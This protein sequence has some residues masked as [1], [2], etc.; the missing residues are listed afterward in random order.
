MKITKKILPFIITLFLFGV[1]SLTL[2]AQTKKDFTYVVSGTIKSSETK[3]PLSGIRIEYK[4]LASAM[5]KEEGNFSIKLPSG[6][7]NLLISGPGYTSKIV[8]VKGRNTINIELHPEGFKSVFEN[9]IVPQG[10]I[11]PLEITSTWSAINEKNILKTDITSDEILQGKV[12]GVNLI[13]RSGDLATG[14]NIY[15]RGLNTMNAGIQPLFVVDGIPYENSLYSTSLIGN[16]FSNPLASIDVKDIESIT[17]LKDGTSQYGVKGANGVVLIRT[18]KAKE[19]ETKINFHLHSGVSFEPIEIPVLNATNHK[20]LLSDILQSKGMSGSDIMSLPYMNDQKP[21]LQKWGYDGNV[22]Y[23]RYNNATNW[24]KEIYNLSKN[25]DY[26]MNVFGG[27][28]VAVYALSIGFL[29]Q[30]GILKNTNYQRFNTRFNSEVN[31]S[32][33]LTLN[34]NMSFLFSSRKLVDEGASPNRNPIFASLVK[35]P[36]MATN[37]YSEEG[38]MSPVIEDYD[39]FNYSNPYSL[40][41]KSDRSNSQFRFV[42]NLKTTYKFNNNFYMDAM[43]GVNF[44]KEREKLFFPYRGVYFDT[45]SVGVV[46]NISQHRV[47]RVF[48]LYSE[49][50]ANYTKTFNLYH[51][52]NVRLGTRYQSNSAEDDWGTIANTG[53]DNFR[54][55]NYGDPLY[56]VIGGQISNWN[57]L[58]IYGS[59]DYAYK[60]KYFLNYTTSADA[61]SRYGREA[62]KLILYPSVSGAWLVSGEEFLKDND[63][64]DLLKLRLGYGLS[65]NDDIGNYSGAQYYVPQNL[66]GNFGLVRGNLVDLNIKPEKSTKINAGFDAA[67]YNER[68]SLIVDIYSTTI[69]DMLVKMPAPRTSGFPFY[70]TNGGVMNNTGLDVAL[71]SRI[72]NG[73][74]KWDVGLNASVYHNIVTDLQDQEYTT[75]LLGADVLTKVGKSLGVFYGYK[76][77]GVYSTQSQ[78]NEDGLYIQKGS[79]KYYFGAG[80][81]R[82]V[83]Q[84]NDK[85]IDENDKVIIGNPN[86][87]LF[88][89]ITSNMSY[90]KLTLGL[91]FTYSLGNDV[92]N[93]TRSQ[94]ESMS[95]YYNQTQAVLNRW[96]AEGDVTSIPRAVYGDPMG[97]ARFSDRWIEDGSY[98][99]LKNVNLSYNLPIK[100]DI[101]R[102]ITVFASGENLFTLTKYKGLDPE[103]ALGQ[104]PLYN[105][106]DATFIPPA[107]TVSLGIKLEL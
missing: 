6:D 54:S 2:Q 51:K 57:W 32:K 88:G 96:K 92:Y 91:L 23:Y 44:N 18:L 28:E 107:R 74:F 68:L 94:L 11:S 26:Y 12:S 1:N 15:I 43:I 27:D 73:I 3:K 106:I 13:H 100:N 36:F 84:N 45:L 78:A 37:V 56:R 67:F 8:S 103:F 83:N 34:A 80:D 14:S 66:L 48:S 105:G 22:D 87:D 102:G 89:S 38:A 47:D 70:L 29:N 85:L 60:D 53:S 64:F 55:V 63:L 21:T 98:I 77:D 52:L 61:S 99:R 76:T 46:D 17:V 41:N 20:L 81:M 58:S 79:Q 10:E 59:A 65:G 71:K 19:M 72:L 33:K 4:Q 39:V 101:L 30:D 42:G 16:Y 35:A 97:N 95:N 7:V 24:Q 25:Q 31:L 104:N 82:F 69:S 50:T 40:V 90:K 49:G 86:P 5:T 93:Y 75:N 62:A 9:I